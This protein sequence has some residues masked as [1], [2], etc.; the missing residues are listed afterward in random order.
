MEKIDQL[1]PAE[2]KQLIY[3]Q[4]LT[5][6]TYTP[7]TQQANIWTSSIKCANLRFKRRTAFGDSI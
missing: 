6:F 4:W 2:Q 7:F 1:S 5:A 3:D